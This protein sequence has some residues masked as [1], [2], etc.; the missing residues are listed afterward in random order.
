MLPVQNIGL[1]VSACYFWRARNHRTLP[2][3]IC[4]ASP[5]ICTQGASGGA[6][7]NEQQRE[8]W[9]H[10]PLAASG[11]EESQVEEVRQYYRSRLPHVRPLW[12][13]AEG[14]VRFEEGAEFLQAW[15][16]YGR[17]A[18]ILNCSVP[19]DRI[20]VAYPLFFGI[21]VENHSELVSLVGAVAKEL[22]RRA[23][24]SSDS[25]MA[26]R[27]Y[28]NIVLAGYTAEDRKT[29]ISAR[30]DS[31]IEVEGRRLS[32]SAAGAALMHSH[33]GS[34][35]SHVRFG[36]HGKYA[37]IPQPQG[38]GSNPPSKRPHRSASDVTALKSIRSLAFE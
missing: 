13:H 35:T 5:R 18:G 14:G 30:R 9:L 29:A 28:A 32:E 7:D 2:E 22:E 38:A 21:P 23:P 26:G 27:H 31:L 37:A 17:L 11:A 19:E 10:G 34:S 24:G 8:A 25:A 36:F 1:C 15:A 12:L 6:E 33:A 3:F 16:M 4:S 20:R